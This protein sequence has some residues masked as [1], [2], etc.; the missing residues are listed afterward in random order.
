[1][2]TIRFLRKDTDHSL[3]DVVK[4]TR[5]IKNLYTLTIR[6][7]ENK[8]E[9]NK[10]DLTDRT[11]FWW[12]RIILRLLSKDSEPFEAIQM[13]MPYMPTVLFDVKNLDNCYNTILDAL[14]FHLDNWEDE[15]LPPLVYS[16]SP[17]TEY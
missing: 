15:E 12:M 1:M 2:L 10:V 6:Y 11:L 9:C 16:P 17:E 8:R 4:I 5:V 3:D 13:D 7:G 14:E